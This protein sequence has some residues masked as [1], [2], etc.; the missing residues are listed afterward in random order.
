MRRADKFDH[1]IAKNIRRFRL[2]RGLSQ[3]ALAASVGVT[4]Q[5]VQKYEN[6]SN[7]IS[8][9]RLFA[10][11][12]ALGVPVQAFSDLQ[13]TSTRIDR[14]VAMLKQ[15]GVLLFLEAY[16]AIPDRTVRALF[17]HWLVSTGDKP[18]AKAQQEEIA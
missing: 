2:A 15:P 3:R 6:A 4:F 10:I 14:F 12:D 11:A 9:S 13:E 16:A 17:L 5:Q 1:I 18:P 7:R 8:A